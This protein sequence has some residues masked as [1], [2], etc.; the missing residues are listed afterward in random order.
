[1]GEFYP[2][3][4]KESVYSTAPVEWATVHSLGESYPFVEKESAY[5]R[6]PA[7]WG[8]RKKIYNRRGM[9]E[10]VGKIRKE[11]RKEGK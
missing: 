1:M 10:E 7:E 11:G 2:S 9:Q 5:S 4:E 3:V 8:R 6:A